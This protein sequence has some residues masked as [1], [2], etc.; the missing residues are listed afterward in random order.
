MTANFF[1]SQ[2]FLIYYCFVSFLR[3]SV[4]WSFW[5]LCAS[6][7]VASRERV[8]KHLTVQPIV[9]EVYLGWVNPEVLRS[10]ASVL[11]GLRC[12]SETATAL[13][14]PS[15][16]NQ[17][18]WTI[19]L[20]L[21]GHESG[22]NKSNLGEVNGPSPQVW[23]RMTS[24]PR[25]I[26]ATGSNVIELTATRTWATIGSPGWLQHLYYY[27]HPS[28]TSRF[29]NV[30]SD[31]TQSNSPSANPIPT[32]RIVTRGRIAN[33]ARKRT[34]T[35]KAVQNAKNWSGQFGSQDLRLEPKSIV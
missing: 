7:Y 27:L 8:C 9:S 19:S 5:Y 25:L 20:C 18:R 13:I 28:W 35:S 1:T 23:P 15:V 6:L 22:A 2:R 11:P 31:L 3:L 14:V 32:G 21:C 17:L 29:F 12:F 4:S 26:H 30:W 34:T 24:N 10:A 33:Q 16:W